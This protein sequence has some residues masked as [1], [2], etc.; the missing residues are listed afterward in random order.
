MVISYTN[1]K[2][3]VLNFIKRNLYNCPPDTKRTAY[4]TLVR[5]IMQYAAPVWD[6]Y[7]NVDIYKLEKVQRQATRWIQSDYSSV[8]SLLSYIDISTLEQCHQSSRLV[9]LYKII[10][11]LLPISIPTYYQHTQF[12]T[13]QHHTNHFVL[14][15]VTLSSYKYSFYP[16]TIKDWNNLSINVIEAR[17]LDEFTYL[18]NV[19][20]CNY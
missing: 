19:N 18:L 6:P 12:H 9:L 7:Y 11:N 8:T 1:N 10:N 15:Q 16:R 14:P 4:L 13:R 3:K 17:D 20:Y 2:G 5:P